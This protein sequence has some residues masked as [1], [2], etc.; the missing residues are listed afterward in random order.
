MLRRQGVSMAAEELLRQHGLLTSTAPASPLPA[1]GRP[2]HVS[3]ALGSGPGEHPGEQPI[4]LGAGAKALK[5]TLG[6]PP[7][8]VGL[9]KVLG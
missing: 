4:R 5:R 1:A 8:G 3:L 6:A 7:A 2:P 9:C